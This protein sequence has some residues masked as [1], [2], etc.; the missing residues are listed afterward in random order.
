MKQSYHVISRRFLSTIIAFTFISQ[1]FMLPSFAWNDVPKA[2][3]CNV[4]CENTCMAS[5]NQII[6]VESDDEQLTFCSSLL[7]G[8]I[9]Y[10][11]LMVLMECGVD[12]S[13][14]TENSSISINYM[15]CTNCQPVLPRTKML[16][17]V[18]FNRDYQVNGCNI[19]VDGEQ[20]AW[21]G[22][23]V[24]INGD[25]YP[26]SIWVDGTIY[27][28]IDPILQKLGIDAHWITN[29]NTYIIEK[30]PL[31]SGKVGIA[32][33]KRD[34]NFSTN[35]FTD[36]P[37]SKWYAEKVKT[38]C[39]YGLMSG[40]S[41]TSFSPEK[42]MSIAEAITIAARL[43]NTYYAK[44]YEFPTGSPWYQPYVEYALE[45]GIISKPYDNYEVPISR[46]E[47][48]IIISNAFP[49]PVIN[50]IEDGVIPD[51]PSGSSYYSAV[52]YLY[53][54]GIISGTDSYGTFN[55]DA[56]ISRAE[57]SV[58][59]GNMVDN[60]LRKHFALPSSIVLPHSTIVPV[61]EA[62][63][64]SVQIT[65]N[66]ALADT[67]ITW[68]SSNPSIATVDSSGRVYGN[69]IGTSTIS[70][71]TPNG[72][73]ASCIVNVQSMA[74][75][76]I[77]FAKDATIRLKGQL[78]F[79]DTLEIYGIWANTFPSKDGTFTTVIYIYYSGE[80]SLGLQSRAEYSAYYTV[81]TQKF[82]VDSDEDHVSSHTL[83]RT[84]DIK[85]VLQ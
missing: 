52:Y 39:Q 51:V 14:D 75:L 56:E 16:E 83:H 55:P 72:K 50:G 77:R 66:S 6:K 10:L 32:N 25:N 84:I 18:T 28:P 24:V 48:A 40:T 19:Y 4:Y 82:I 9:V 46:G 21:K 67:Q 17:T 33:F 49:L 78:K 27:F 60:S 1:I 42:N 8:K 35:Q 13:L 79:P 74:E 44:Q 53:R 22:K 11:P 15:D 5:E 47:F 45:E 38:V 76:D 36:V 71:A 61:G 57:V 23:D 43:N 70:A 26:S 12:F 85:K 2:S 54:A 59:L 73:T 68:T 81:E 64:I 3:A 58:I 29:T 34:E 80:N 7:C 63:T 41:S 37:S 31:Q 20:M 62:Q 30:T 65:P 69:K